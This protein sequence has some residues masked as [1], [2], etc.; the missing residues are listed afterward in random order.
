MTHTVF[1]LGAGASKD[2][3][4]PMMDNFIDVAER[5]R[6]RNQTGD[7]R[8]SFDLVF[9]GLAELREVHEKAAFNT[10]NLESVF[11]AFEMAK[12]LGRLG[13]LGIDKINRLPNAMRD[14][15]VQTIAE[16]VE[17][18][19][20]QDDRGHSAIRPPAPYPGLIDVIKN[21]LQAGSQGRDRFSFSIITFNYD[22]C[23]DFALYYSSLNIRYGLE[24]GENQDAI[25]LL[26]LHGSLLWGRCSG[27][28]KVAAWPLSTTRNRFWPDLES[29]SS[30]KFPVTEWLKGF[31]HCAGGHMSQ[32][33]V[34]PPTWSK[35]QYHTELESVWRNAAK[36]LQKA[37]NIFVS[38]YSLPEA[39]QFFK[40]LYALGTSGTTRLKKFWVFDP[41]PTVEMSFKTLIGESILHRFKFFKEP[42]SQ[43]VG[44]VQSAL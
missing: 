5:L 8:G 19:V 36:E 4:A 23:L 11:G 37:E 21:R 30:V 29:R 39:D 16:T 10:Y 7:V 27:C 17:F 32:A 3:G 22:V 44:V 14:V 13:S 12:L 31:A 26:K 6:T 33:Y 41:N 34:V 42:F 28:N 35:G 9:E 38:G 20:V 1:I 43:M 18:P 25:A 24:D 15:I 2:A 40:L